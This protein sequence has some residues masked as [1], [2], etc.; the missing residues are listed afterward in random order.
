MYKVVS[1]NISELLKAR[2]FAFAVHN[3]TGAIYLSTSG[4]GKLIRDRNLDKDTLSGGWVLTPKRRII[5][6]S[7][8]V[9]G[10]AKNKAAVCIAIE[11]FLRVNL[12]MEV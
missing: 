10:V 8:Y 2:Q 4:H 7:G 6:H 3:L 1:G 5:F 12:D 9:G 11:S